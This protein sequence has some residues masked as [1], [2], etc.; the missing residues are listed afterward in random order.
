MRAPDSRRAKVI[1]SWTGAYRGQCAG[2]GTLEGPPLHARCWD[3]GRLRRSVAGRSRPSG[4]RR[5][6]F[7]ADSSGRSVRRRHRRRKRQGNSSRRQRRS[8][9]EGRRR[10]RPHPG[11]RGRKGNR[12]GKGSRTD[13]K[14]RARCKARSPRTPG[15]GSDAAWQ[16]PTRRCSL[17]Q[18]SRTTFRTERPSRRS[19]RTAGVPK[20]VA[21]TTGC[22]HHSQPSAQTDS[23]ANVRAAECARTVGAQRRSG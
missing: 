2:H 3:A 13:R 17:D 12:R 15:P 7:P 20:A 16:L 9:R 4:R 5:K 1:G 8:E 21:A 10:K 6:R 18:S 14:R 19:R 11:T 23:G 22:T